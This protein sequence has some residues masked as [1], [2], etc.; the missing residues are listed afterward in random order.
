MVPCNLLLYQQVDRI[1]V[2]QSLTDKSASQYHLPLLLQI[3]QCL[4]IS[5]LSIVNAEMP[6][7][8][9]Q[10]QGCH[11]ILYPPESI[12]KFIHNSQIPNLEVPNKTFLCFVFVLKFCQY[13]LQTSIIG[14]VSKSILVNQRRWD[15]WLLKVTLGSYTVPGNLLML[16]LLCCR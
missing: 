5:Q 11:Y 15:F 3:Y 6:K 13:L 10:K 8:Y 16:H 9:F 2:N 14:H 4:H 12:D 1:K 7:V